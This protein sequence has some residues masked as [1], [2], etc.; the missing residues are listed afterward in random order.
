MELSLILTKTE[1]V[2]LNLIWVR[3]E[4]SKDGMKD[5]PPWKEEREQLLS[6]HLI[7]LM[8][9]EAHHLESHQ[10]QPYTLKLNFLT[11]KTKLNKNGNWV[12]SKKSLKQQLQKIKETKLSKKENLSKLTNSI[13]KVLNLLK[14]MIT[15]KLS[16]FLKFLDWT[17]L[18]HK[19][20]QDNIL[21]QSITVVKFYKKILTIWKLFTEEVLLT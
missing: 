18:N 11:S 17:L 9:K 12:M 13:K 5:L 3:E 6:A 4:S 19:S 7:M 8:A 2:P 15:Q 1:T 16:K 14:M 10:I 20:K 21:K